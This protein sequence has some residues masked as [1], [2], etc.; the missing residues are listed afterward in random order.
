MG[1]TDMRGR[2]C[3]ILTG[4]RVPKGPPGSNNTSAAS[5]ACKFVLAE[6][7]RDEIEENLLMHAQRVPE[8]DADQPIEGRQ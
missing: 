8:L 6:A 3:T 4:S 7:V 1:C 5:R 2:V